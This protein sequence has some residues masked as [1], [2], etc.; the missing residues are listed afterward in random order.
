MRHLRKILG[1]IFLANLLAVGAAHAET[2]IW[3]DDFELNPAASWTSTG[4]W[5]IGS[6]ASGPVTNNLGY[7]THSGA[8]CAST[9]G[10]PYSQ[11]VRLICTNYNGANFLSIPTAN[12]FPRLRFWHWFNF[13]N[14]LGY[15]EISTNGS[16]WMQLS[17]TYELNSSGAFINSSGVWS[18]PS[19]D[20]TAYSGTSVQLAFHFT[21]GCCYGNGL[22]W[23]VDDVEVDTGTPL[24]NLPESF[25]FDPKASDWS[26]DFGT[27][28][29]GKPT[30]GPPTNSLGYRA[31]NG[32]NCAGTVLNGDYANAADTRL[33]SPLFI[34]PASG[35]PTLSYYQ[36][37]SFNNARGFVEINN[38]ITSSITLTNTVITT[39]VVANGL[40]TNIYQLF[41]S[42]DTNYSTPL[43][44]NSTIRGWTNGT[45]AMG[46]VPDAY[47]LGQ[48]YFEVG[49][50]PLS[51]IGQLYQADYRVTSFLPT[52][53]S[54]NTNFLSLQGV[55]WTA[56]ALGGSPVGYFGTNYTYSYT[57]NTT[58][59]T[60]SSG[61][62]T[63]IS[64]TYLNVGIGTWTNATLD[65]SQYAGQVVEIAFHFNS[66]NCCGTSSGW[67][68]DDLSML[69]TPTFTVPT[70]QVI[71]FGQ[72]FTNNLAAT[73]SNETSP[74]F[75]Y[76]LAAP[77]TNAVVTGNKVAWT[78]AAT[79]P[80][81]YPIYVKVTDNGVVSVTNSFSVTV[82][83][84]PSQIVL[85]NSAF[86]T[87]GSK[88][89][90]FSVNT[91]W[92]NTTWRVVATTNLSNPAWIPIYTN[93]PAA[94]G[95]V[96]FT[97]TLSTNFLRR[98]Y[99]AVFP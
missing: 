46:A 69:T 45:K 92:T 53:G 59:S 28:E 75:S 30:S 19:I 64:P 88:K 58:T 29:I 82:M 76:G 3:S 65:L 81:T 41:G 63:Q 16:N 89:F 78:N 18:R 27:W 91:P 32:T 85:T 39:N 86:S 11:D 61:S 6:P 79:A 49:A 70:N 33:I 15:V 48:Y 20:L 77:S 44:W 12:F 93:Q 38:G 26:V 90:V 9:Q 80:G 4:V 56:D 40:N 10:Y 66:G 73:N 2:A 95:T 35:G 84:L 54:A 7:R 97:D 74:T 24:L 37:Y 5:H 68:V 99:R 34:V 36:W 98:Y 21:C 23:Y 47:N 14:A 62:W 72:T 1:C 17:P 13:D 25:E 83:L 96:T 71:L 22:G 8:N 55:T 31:H 60:N 57:T 94:G 52:P 42:P 87:N 50:A 67:Y 43:Y 51:S